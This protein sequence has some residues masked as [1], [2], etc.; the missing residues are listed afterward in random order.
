MPGRGAPCNRTPLPPY[1]DDIIATKGIYNW[2]YSI[3]YI[4]TIVVRSH[5]PCSSLRGGLASLSTFPQDAF[6]FLSKQLI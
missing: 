5:F 3:V 2:N 4:T 1:E 6:Y